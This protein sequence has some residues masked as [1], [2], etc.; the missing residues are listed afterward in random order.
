MK[1]SGKAT[2]P[3]LTARLA[4]RGLRSTSH[5]EEV[6]SVLAQRR[7]HPTAEQV[8]LRTKEGMPEISMATVY[9]C[10]DALVQCGLVREVNLDRGATRYCANMGPHS[11]FYCDGCG[12]VYDIDYVGR[13]RALELHLP[14]GFEAVRYD[15]SIHGACPECAAR[16]RAGEKAGKDPI[17]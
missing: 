14:T 3:Q 4:A 9:N 8:F 11:H 15:V 12:S 5:R 16:A 7:D 13:F 17:L 1:P 2:E 6:Y 10:L